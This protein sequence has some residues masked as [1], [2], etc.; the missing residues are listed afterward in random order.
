MKFLRINN[1]KRKL[2][3][4]FYQLKRI[5]NVSRATDLG[6]NFRKLVCDDND[7]SYKSTCA[8]E[9]TVDETGST[10]I[11]E[12]AYELSTK[13]VRAVG[14][15]LGRI[16]L[17]SVESGLAWSPQPGLATLAWL[18]RGLAGRTACA[19]SWAAARAGSQGSNARLVGLV[20]GLPEVLAGGGAGQ[21]RK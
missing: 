19:P 18:V 12:L 7:R 3:R 9:K 1:V 11:K 15:G 16:G 2:K 17:G 14:P 4:T 8:N 10:R 5:N 21:R 13:E 20:L 6:I